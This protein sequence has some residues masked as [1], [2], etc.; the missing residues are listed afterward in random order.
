MGAVVSYVGEGFGDVFRAQVKNHGGG[1][2]YFGKSILHFFN[3]RELSA[4]HLK[5]SQCTT[6]KIQ[7]HMKQV[8]LRF[9]KCLLFA[10]RQ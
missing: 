10:I 6:R 7:R 2:W 9:N 5:T 8:S 1:K 4:L 3:M